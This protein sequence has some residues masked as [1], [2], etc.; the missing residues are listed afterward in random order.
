MSAN[1]VALS[2]PTIVVSAA[3][4]SDVVWVASRLRGAPTACSRPTLSAMRLTRWPSA[5]AVGAAVWATAPSLS[6]LP[7]SAEPDATSPATGIE[8][9]LLAITTGAEFAMVA[10][11]LP[12]TLL[13]EIAT[14]SAAS[15]RVGAVVPALT[16]ATLPPCDTTV[17]RVWSLATTT[18]SE[19]AITFWPSETVVPPNW[20]RLNGRVDWFE[21]IAT[22]IEVAMMAWPSDTATPPNWTIFIA[23]VPLTI[24]VTV[25][26]TTV[27]PLTTAVTVP[28]TAAVTVP[29]TG[30]ADWFDAIATGSELAITAW[31]SMAVPDVLVGIDIIARMPPPTSVARNV[32]VV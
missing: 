24:A 6:G 4:V 18:G 21:A 9:W 25:P 5:T 27:V 26:L 28:L 10:W 12:F 19:V 3:V 7:L 2:G 15:P 14:T 23:A 29:L 11:P 32:A 31:P 17:V 20:T 1:V 8:L 13:G 22:G 30:I 16:A